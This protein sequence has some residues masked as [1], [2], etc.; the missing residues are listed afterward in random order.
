MPL[1]VACQRIK[2]TGQTE[3]HLE[4][5]DSA[6]QN[7]PDGVT[8]YAPIFDITPPDLIHEIVTENGQMTPAEAGLKG[9]NTAALLNRILDTGKF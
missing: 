3:A 4:E 5:R 1:Y 7:L 6:F 8:G 9:K 2:L